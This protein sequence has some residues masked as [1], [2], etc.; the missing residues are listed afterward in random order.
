MKS[1]NITLILNKIREHGSISRVQIAKETGLTPATVTNLTS[2]LL[3]AGI[4]VEADTG[5]STGGRKP[6]M[7]KFNTSDYGI[8]SAYIS[9]VKVEFAVANF[10]ADI[11]YYNSIPLPKENSVEKS[12]EFIEKQYAEYSRTTNRKISGL[13]L[14]LHGIVDTDSGISVFAPNLDWRNVPIGNML[15]ERLNLPVFADN[16]VRLMT[17]GEMWYGVAKNVS[18]LVFVYIGSGIGGAIVINGNLY[19]GFKNGS[20]EIG[21]CTIDT[22]GDMCSCGNRGCVQTKAN[23]NA[24]LNAM[25]SY[26]ADEAS[27]LSQDSGCADIVRA[28]IYNSDPVACRVINDEARYLGIT[29]NNLINMFNPKMVVVNSDIKDFD[30]AVMPGLTEEAKKRKMKFFDSS[31]EIKYSHL[32]EMAVLKGGIAMVLKKIC[33]STSLI[34]GQ[35]S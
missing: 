18:D 21:H 23:R 1:T 27:I 35:N 34:N 32:G 33:E 14:G 13:G 6:I 3:T 31:T 2:E 10:E 30:K 4:I 20:G 5:C 24:M 28:C 26:I 29:V 17:I 12:M 8:C 7:L 11:I 25:K 16:D 22:D 19:N 9:P 15:Q